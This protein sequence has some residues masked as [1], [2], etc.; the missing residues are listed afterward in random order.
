MK[1]LLD[2]KTIPT[3]LRRNAAASH[4]GISPSFFDQL[5]SERVLPQPRRL[6]VKVRV[7]VRQELDDALLSLPVEQ[8]DEAF[9]NPCDRLLG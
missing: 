9:N 6:G 8:G 5:V 4:C 7:W 2:A 1:T 3:G